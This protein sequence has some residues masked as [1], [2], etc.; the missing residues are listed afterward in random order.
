MAAQALIARKNIGGQVRSHDVAH[1]NLG[2]GVWPGDTNENI[3]RHA[4]F[5]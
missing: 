3:F 1:V 5:S 4:D 2:V